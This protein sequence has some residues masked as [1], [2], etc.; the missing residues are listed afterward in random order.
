MT[1]HVEQE[2]GEGSLYFHG[3]H[4]L[5][6]THPSLILVRF[7]LRFLE[8]IQSRY[9]LYM[10]D[11]SNTRKR[12]IFRGHLDLVKFSGTHAGP[13]VRRSSISVLRGY[14]IRRKN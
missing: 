1:D 12:L 8:D 13:C 10:Y 6:D 14:Y 3:Y 2:V 7:D 4:S 9:A 11:R 5:K